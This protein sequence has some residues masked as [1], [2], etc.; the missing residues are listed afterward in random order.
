MSAMVAGGLY[1]IENE[2]TLEAACDGNAY[3]ADDAA[4]MPST[5]REAL[6]TC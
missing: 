3:Q 4:R 6:G 2:L 5:L 1:G